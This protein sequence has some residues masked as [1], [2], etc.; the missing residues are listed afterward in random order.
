M[1][2]VLAP[3]GGSA[4]PEQWTT[5]IRAPNTGQ[6]LKG[7]QF[8]AHRLTAQVIGIVTANDLTARLQRFE[9]GT[10]FDEVWIRPRWIARD[11]VPDL[12]PEL[13][14]RS[15]EEETRLQALIAAQRARARTR[16]AREA[17]QRRQQL[18]Q[19]AIARDRERSEAAYG[20][21]DE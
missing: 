17:A 1:L 4:P 3:I 10:G 20:S 18:N 21:R 12:F 5:L 11:I 6:L 8:N 16:E 2:I 15:A 9:G 7:E 19:A 14:T 13:A